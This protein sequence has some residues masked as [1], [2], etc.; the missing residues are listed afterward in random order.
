MGTAMHGTI[1]RVYKHLKN[2]GILPATNDV[3]AWFDELLFHERLNEKDHAHMLVRGRDALKRF[4]EEK[5]NSFSASDM[6]EFDFKNQGVV[7]GDAHLT[8][9]ID[10]IIVADGA[11][12][13]SDLK[14]GRAIK[15]WSP[16]DPYDKI[17]AWK[18]RR[19]LAFYKLLIEHSREFGGKY[20]MNNGVIEFMEPLN[21][22]I[23]DLPVTI[24]K[25]EI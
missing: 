19:Q 18:Y 1:Q 24:E 6:I 25:D 11:I 3:L 12:T 14:T 23:V 17:K 13:V 4:Y 9:K 15:N 8:G 10:K 2:G 21:D 7:V 20:T 16:S 5:K 22:Q